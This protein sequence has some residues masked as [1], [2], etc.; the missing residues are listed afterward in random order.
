MT[1]TSR[2][3]RRDRVRRRRDAGERVGCRRRRRI[4]Q[5]RQ[6]RRQQ[7]EAG[8]LMMMQKVRTR[9]LI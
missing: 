5:R 8:V 2:F 9:L 4:K 1:P 3:R 6:R 7:T